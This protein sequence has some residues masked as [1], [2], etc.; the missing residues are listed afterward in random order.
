L[1]MAA[2]KPAD[3]ASVE[4]PSKGDEGEVL[5]NAPGSYSKWRPGAFNFLSG[6]PAGSSGGATHN[7]I[8]LAQLSDTPA[9]VQHPLQIV[10]Q[11]FLAALDYRRNHAANPISLFNFQGGLAHA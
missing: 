4:N 5:C 7:P 2:G 6:T 10:P 9:G 11:G 3:D 1:L 8:K